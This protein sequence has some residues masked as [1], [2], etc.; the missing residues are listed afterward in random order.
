MFSPSYSKATKALMLALA[1]SAASY[2]FASEP[3]A[4]GDTQRGKKIYQQ[5]C[6]ACHGA[7]GRGTIPGVGDFTAASGPLV[8]EDVVLIQSI[9]EGL[10]T[11]G[12]PLTMPA[13]G[14]NPSLCDEDILAVL[15]YLRAEFGS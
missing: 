3:P 4:G 6:I 8:K 5:T 2:S 1:L 9:T 7:N 13:K 12:A 11:P 15:A 10:A 14:G